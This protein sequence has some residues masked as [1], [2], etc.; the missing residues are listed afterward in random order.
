MSL[1]VCKRVQKANVGSI[2]KSNK[3]TTTLHSYFS[4]EHISTFN[5]SPESR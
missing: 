2:K 1:K 3:I 5:S 4:E